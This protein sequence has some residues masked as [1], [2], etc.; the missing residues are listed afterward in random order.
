MCNRAT[1]RQHQHELDMK[2]RVIKSRSV[3]ATCSI[4][5]AAL[6][7]SV[8]GDAGW[9]RLAAAR[10]HGV[11]VQ[12]VDRMDAA[13]AGIQPGDVIER[14]T[15]RPCRASR[16][17]RGAQKVLT[18]SAAARQQAGQWRIRDSSSGSTDEIVQ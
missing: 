16:S 5:Q 12:D 11:V 10:R 8:A 18:V 17:A 7:V 6:G 2:R 4:D 14:S 13:D 15:V 9:P 1:A 3:T